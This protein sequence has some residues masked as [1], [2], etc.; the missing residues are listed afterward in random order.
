MIDKLLIIKT[1]DGYSLETMLSLP[2]TKPNKLV[3]FV[4]GSGPFTY[5]TIRQK[6][7]GSIFRYF[8][9]FASEFT[10]RG[11]AFCRYNT[12]G[13]VDGETPPNYTKINEKEY[14][15]YLPHNSVSDLNSIITYLYEEGYR[16]T[17]IYLLGWSEGSIIAPLVALNQSLN[18]KGLLLC[19]YCNENLYDTLV[20]QMNG[21]SELIQNRRLFDY[22]KKGYI[23]KKDFEE[24]RYHVR[25]T[26]FFDKTFEQLDMDSD[27]KITA[28]DFALNS[29][30]YLAEMLIAIDKGDD[31]WLKKNHG[32]RL[33]SAWFKEH[34]SLEPNKNILPKLNLPI[35]IFA[36]E[37]DAMTP[38]Y[39]A[40][41]IEIRFQK[42]G[43]MNL[44]TYIFENHDHDLNYA[45]YLFKG[46]LSEGLLS[47]FNVVEK[48][49]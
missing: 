47:I 18:I 24:D 17:N 22:D 46:G 41:D 42:L 44:K 27:G 39:N 21:N 19:G 20:W 1:Q 35:H 14:L 3:L 7:D 48:I 29:Q 23:T 12:R 36:G 45:L 43:K 8:D 15:S 6:A 49:Q 5:N 33:T 31:E 30:K 11:I 38:A 10:K 9:L 13:V 4:N 26:I 16:D 40:L 28:A 25:E 32:I 37:Y 2:E 34:F